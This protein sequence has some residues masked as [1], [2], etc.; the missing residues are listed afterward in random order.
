MH[1]FWI[2]SFRATIYPPIIGNGNRTVDKPAVLRKISGNGF[3]AAYFF[4][5][6]FA[7]KPMLL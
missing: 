1:H 3:C 5:Q 6:G 2:L 7:L 4:E